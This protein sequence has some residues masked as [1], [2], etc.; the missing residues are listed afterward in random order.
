MERAHALDPTI[1]EIAPFVDGEDVA[2]ALA[3][4]LGAPSVALGAALA[5]LTLPP[6]ED[7]PL[8]PPET[9]RSVTGEVLSAALRYQLAPITSGMLFA[10]HPFCAISG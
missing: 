10:V 9:L 2:L 4:A 5:L 3:L 8:G 7:V 6:V 1:T